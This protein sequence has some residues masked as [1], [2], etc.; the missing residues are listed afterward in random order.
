MFTRKEI[1]AHRNKSGKQKPEDTSKP[2]KNTGLERGLKF[3]VQRY[4][5]SDT[6]YTKVF[7]NSFM[8]EES[9]EPA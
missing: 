3:Q 4:L 1:D 9:V 2:I 7:N 6:V 5:S 8:V